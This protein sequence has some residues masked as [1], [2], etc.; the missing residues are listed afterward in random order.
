MLKSS[1]RV[2]K[3]VVASRASFFTPI[4]LA[5]FVTAFAYQLFY[6][7]APFI[8]SFNFTLPLGEYVPAIRIFIRELRN[9]M[10]VYVLYGLVHFIIAI[11][12][13]LYCLIN[14]ISVPSLRQT[15]LIL[16]A[17][18]C[19]LLFKTVGF[20]PP[21]AEY[22]RSLLHDVSA[23]HFILSVLGIT[24]LLSL[25]LKNRQTLLIAVALFLFPVC[26]VASAHYSTEDYEYILFPAMRILRGFSLNQTAFQYDHLL[27]LLAALWMKLGFSIY[28][29]NLVGQISVYAFFMGLYLFG[30]RFFTHKCY[31]LYLLISA[32]LVRMYGN[33]VDIVACFQVTPLRLD[34]WFIVLLAVFFKGD[35]H[36]VTGLVLGF[37]LIF[38]HA[39]GVI[40]TL[41][42]GLLVIFFFC[43]DAISKKDP[44]RTVSR[45]YVALYA[46]NVFL[47][48]VSLLIY[49]LFFTCGS[50]S[51]ATFR[52]TGIGFMRISRQSFYWYVPMMLSL[53]FIYHWRGRDFLSARHF[54]A[55]IFL[56]LLAIGNSL[57]F[58]GR[59]HE[60]NIINISSI[61]LFCL[62]FLFDLVHSE[63]ERSSF[64]K[65]SKWILP[66]LAV[67]FILGISVVYAGR[68]SE[69]LRNQAVNLWAN[70][71]DG[72]VRGFEQYLHAHT[73]YIKE[74][75]RFN[76][77][78]MFVSGLAA[79]YYYESGYVPQSHIVLPARFFMKD[80]V[81]FLNA[82]LLKGYYLVMPMADLE[83]YGE[84]MAHLPARHAV[85]DSTMIIISNND[86]G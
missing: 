3:S 8:W 84:V 44:L 55:G 35:A 60:H 58:F 48:G 78:V 61:L 71:A 4:V 51:A 67:V 10:Q 13:L 37:L 30:R 69:R 7:Y 33:L 38:H 53:A 79:Y 77:K 74:L 19:L 17:L 63:F 75:T 27:S 50:S 25:L 39:F 59:S 47:I 45:N 82:Q 26:M 21:F 40:Y 80:L 46:K 5:G 62:F 66:L 57:Y 1:D 28:S 49:Y 86:I 14:K 6:L 72:R 24:I 31:A 22:S 23:M 20:F 70:E 29:F 32:V 81:D 36:W 83:S 43:M 76:P 11:T 12:F 42:Y 41:A 73:R 85:S 52:K 2:S 15:F 64:S 54:R 56:I 65:S 18:P 68:A 16:F 34:W 9:G